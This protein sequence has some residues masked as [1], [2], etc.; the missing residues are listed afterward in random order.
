VPWGVAQ[1]EVAG[2]YLRFELSRSDLKSTSEL[3]GTPIAFRFG[4]FENLEFRLNTFGFA[5]SED[6]L[7]VGPGPTT[8]RSDCGFSFPAIGLKWQLLD[9][10]DQGYRPY[11]GVI[12]SWDLP[13]GSK[14]FRPPKNRFSTTLLVD[15]PLP[16]DLALVFNAGVGFPYDEITRRRFVQGLGAVALVAPVGGGTS[17]FLE[18]AGEGPQSDG[19]EWQVLVDG[20]LL[21]L[22]SNSVQLDLAVQRGLTQFST[23]WGATVGLSFYLF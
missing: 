16:A 1:V 20:G 10:P 12:I 6:R 11:L 4:L 19:G 9:P 7:T 2:E 17:C 23:D 14:N 3:F 5:F 22:L 15:V 13:Y 21:F 8:K 18:I